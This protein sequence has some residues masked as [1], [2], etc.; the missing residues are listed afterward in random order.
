MLSKLFVGLL[1]S[2]V[3]V[4]ANAITQKELLKF[5]TTQKTL[6]FKDKV[7]DSYIKGYW[8]SKI[9]KLNS[10]L[11]PKPKALKTKKKMSIADKYSLEL[12]L[13][14]KYNNRYY[15]KKP[16]VIQGN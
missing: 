10:Y 8:P 13:N 3:I 1:L 6:Y 11:K 9:N 5:Q 2:S 4:M 12:K 14:N 15:K 7:D 16:K